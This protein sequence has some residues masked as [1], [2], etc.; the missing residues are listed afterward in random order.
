MEIVVNRECTPYITG[1]YGEDLTPCKCPVCG[2]FLPS[3]IFQ[4]P[5]ICKRCGSMLKAFEVTE[6]FIE[7]DNY[8]GEEGRICVLSKEHNHKGKQQHRASHQVKEGRKAWKAF[9]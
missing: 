6:K 1:N 2:G 3:D 4:D 8:Q 9:L 5:L 7:S